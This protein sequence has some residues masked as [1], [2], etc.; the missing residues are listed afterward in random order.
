MVDINDTCHIHE[1]VQNLLKEIG[2][3]GQLLN[4]ERWQFAI[5]WNQLDKR[6]SLFYA[7]SIS[8][9]KKKCAICNQ[10]QTKLDANKYFE[11]KIDCL[12][13]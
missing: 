10:Q 11:P 13:H 12:W 8:K 4:T 2:Q 5:K 9:Y 3:I 7:V 6:Q 1:F